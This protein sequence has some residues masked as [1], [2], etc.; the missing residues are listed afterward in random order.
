MILLLYCNPVPTANSGTAGA[1]RYVRP[2]RPGRISR[3]APEH[4]MVGSEGLSES[5]R[6]YCS[7]VPAS[8]GPVRVPPDFV[9]PSIGARGRSAARPRRNRATNHGVRQREYAHHIPQRRRWTTMYQK[10]TSVG[11]GGYAITPPIAA[12]GSSPAC[13]AA[14]NFIGVN[15]RSEPAQVADYGRLRWASIQPQK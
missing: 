4:R 11:E 3:P 13:V 1:L 5:V 10:R 15:P 8:G 7:S 9:V 6:G 2:A 14:P 12:P